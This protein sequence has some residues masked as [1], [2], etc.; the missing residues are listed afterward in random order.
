MAPGREGRGPAARV[1][2]V[3]FAVRKAAPVRMAGRVL[4]AGSAAKAEI[5]FP[6]RAARTAPAAMAGEIVAHRAKPCRG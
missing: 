1:R 4:A 6:G 2:P 3:D 5:V